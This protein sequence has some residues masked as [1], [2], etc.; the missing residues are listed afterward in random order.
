M[1]LVDPAAM[2]DLQGVETHEPNCVM[3]GLAPSSFTYDNLTT[4]F[5]WQKL[6]HIART[7]E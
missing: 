4:A 1:F 2:E 5:R 6:L 3:L 7:S